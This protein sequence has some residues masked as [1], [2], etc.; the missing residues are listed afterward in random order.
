M[1]VFTRYFCVPDLGKSRGIR[2]Q[3]LMGGLGAPELA[4]RGVEACLRDINESL[5]I[6]RSWDGGIPPKG[7]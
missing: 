4:R 2:R 7:P 5:R 1:A 3:R 6:T